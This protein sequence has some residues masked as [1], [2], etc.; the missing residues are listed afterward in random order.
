MFSNIMSNRTLNSL[1]GQCWME[2]NT[3]E[4]RIRSEI[5][6]I[7]TADKRI[8]DGLFSK[9]HEAAHRTDVTSS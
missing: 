1:E 8:E 5:K 6:S 4:T 2:R 3:D 9:E 7:V